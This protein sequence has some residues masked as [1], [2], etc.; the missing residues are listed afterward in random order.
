MY[1]GN[2]NNPEA[3]EAKDQYFFGSEMI[4]API[5]E[6]ARPGTTQVEKRVW[7]PDG[8]WVNFFTGEE[9]PGGGWHLT[10]ADL[11]DIPCYAKPGAIIPLGPVAA[12]GG[13]DNPTTLD[14]FVFPGADNQFNLF[15]DDGGT[16]D[17][18]RGKYC[19]T[20]FSLKADRFTIHPAEG[21]LALIP[22]DRTYRI[23]LRGVEGSV[24]ASIPGSYDPST[25]TFSMDPFTLS[26]K[27]GRSVQF[28]LSSS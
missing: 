16:T 11:E 25:R 19:I 22:P 10:R 6:P 24:S 3:F 8:R 26:S 23:H 27:E 15:E 13:L 5:T 18:L 2:M 7:L 14:V 17:Y 28:K 12:W 21:D 9:L 1:Y 20:R 4:V